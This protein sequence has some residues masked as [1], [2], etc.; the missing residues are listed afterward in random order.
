M[1]PNKFHYE[2]LKDRGTDAKPDFKKYFPGC[3]N[4]YSTVQFND[5][6]SQ[7]ELILTTGSVI[8]FVGPKSAGHTMLFILGI[9]Y[10]DAAKKDPLQF[11]EGTSSM[12]L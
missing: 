4:V 1:L 11:R 8:S 9:L 12:S 7:R 10:D 2:F 6:L 3:T 5:L